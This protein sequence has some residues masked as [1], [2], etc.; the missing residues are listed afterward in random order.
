M[1]ALFAPWLVSKS[2]GWSSWTYPLRVPLK[3]SSSAQLKE[4]SV[5]SS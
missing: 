4:L 1:T 2:V 5:T 3:R